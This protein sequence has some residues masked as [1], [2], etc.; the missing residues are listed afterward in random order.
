V[1]TNHDRKGHKPVTS[2][3]FLLFAC[4]QQTQRLPYLRPMGLN[5]VVDIDQ[6]EGQSPDKFDKWVQATR[7]NNLY[8]IHGPRDPDP[9]SPINKQDAEDPLFIA[10]S[11]MDEPDLHSLSPQDLLAKRAPFSRYG[12]PWF[13]NFDG[14]RLA[15]IQNPPGTPTPPVYQQLVALTDIACEDVYPVSGW[16]NNI[17]IDSHVPCYNALK[18]Y[19]GPSRPLMAYVETCVQNLPW[20]P[21]SQRGPSPAE[22][23]AQ[24]EILSRFASLPGYGLQGIGFFTNSQPTA[25]PPPK[26]YS[27]WNVSPQIDARIGEWCRRLE[28]AHN[29]FP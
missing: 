20:L 21:P 18:Q 22:F 7:D 5:A 1:D 23:D 10:W 12:K 16:D 8:R 24:M 11:F 17:P 4:Q 2:F 29:V 26:P 3:P 6:T 9:D 13:G 15:Q 19:A 25:G 27:C 28:G 14:S